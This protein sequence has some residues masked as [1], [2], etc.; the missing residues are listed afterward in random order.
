[1]A[2]CVPRQ[3]SEWKHPRVFQNRTRRTAKHVPFFLSPMR[4]SRWCTGSTPAH[5]IK[6]EELYLFSLYTLFLKNVV[7]SICEAV[8][9]STSQKSLPQKRS[10]R[11]NE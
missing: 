3:R 8:N 2:A 9:L 5:S 6:Q 10:E 1:M 7:V 4:V 11:S